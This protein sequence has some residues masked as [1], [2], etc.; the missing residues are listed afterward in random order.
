MFK[1]LASFF[2]F[3]S[4]L[5]TQAYAAT[6]KVDVDHSSVSFKI[7][8]LLSKTQGQFK[9]FDGR[10][11]FEPGKPETWSAQGTI[12]VASIDTNSEKRDQHLLSADF[13]E[14]EKNPTIEFRTTGVVD[15]TETSAKVE[16]VLKLHGVERP[17]V[18]DVTI[19]GVATD[20]W[21]NTRSAFTAVTVIN[22]KD[23]GMTYN[24]TL[25]KGGLLLG[26]EVEITLEI[27]GILEPAA[28]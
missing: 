23:F 1:K 3:L 25:D 2:I 8:H 17:V 18:L 7:K 24:Q 21:G 4:V 27:E 13:F 11:V 6:Y 22:R 5:T 14:A 20:P 9:K 15:A 12:D 19:A 26:E 16:G 28:A 10:I